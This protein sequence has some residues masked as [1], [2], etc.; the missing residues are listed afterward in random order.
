MQDGSELTPK[1]KLET[2]QGWHHRV[3]IAFAV[4]PDFVAVL[5]WRCGWEGPEA[6]L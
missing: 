2:G 4:E 5:S 1:A 3:I 6:G